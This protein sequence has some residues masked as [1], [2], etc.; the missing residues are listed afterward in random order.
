MNHFELIETT[1]NSTLAL[2]CPVSESTEFYF[3]NLYCRR[4]ARR[5]C[6]ERGIQSAKEVSKRDR[7][8]SNKTPDGSFPGLPW[9]GQVKFGWTL[10]W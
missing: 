8:V 7:S 3:P 5:Y 10:W 4:R 9:R 2:S 6:V 1:N